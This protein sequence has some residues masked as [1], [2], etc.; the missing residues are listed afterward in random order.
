M[1]ELERY[2]AAYKILVEGLQHINK[3]VSEHHVGWKGEVLEA[4]NHA[5]LTMARAAQALKEE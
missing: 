2:K 4:R 3:G 1:T 5:R